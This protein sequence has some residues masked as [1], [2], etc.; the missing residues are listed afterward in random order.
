MVTFGVMLKNHL[1]CLLFLCAIGKASTQVNVSGLL[2]D[3]I[4]QL[5]LAGVKIYTALPAETMSDASGRFT[6]QHEANPDISLRLDFNGETTK[7]QT[8]NAGVSDVDLGNIMVDLRPSQSHERELPTISLE[9]SDDQSDAN[10]S[11]L[12]QSG[13]D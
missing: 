11:G 1:L 10:I 8:T 12:F 6:I 2:L 9:E 3:D 4:T 7:Y 5:P 13:D